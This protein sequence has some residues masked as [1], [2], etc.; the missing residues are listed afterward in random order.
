MSRE[1]V[2]IKTSRFYGK[3]RAERVEAKRRTRNS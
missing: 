1:D 2:E 3:I